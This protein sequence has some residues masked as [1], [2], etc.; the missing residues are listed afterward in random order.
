MINSIV[1]DSVRNMK[2]VYLCG[3]NSFQ[4]VLETK[5]MQLLFLVC[6]WCF[7][8]SF[9]SYIMQVCQDKITI[10]FQWSN[11]WGHVYTMRLPSCGVTFDYIAVS[12]DH[13]PKH[14]MTNVKSQ[15]IHAVHIQ[16]QSFS[17]ERKHERNINSTSVIWFI[18][19]QTA[20]TLPEIHVLLPSV[21]PHFCC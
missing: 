21:F 1:C 9:I 16:S 8:N 3:E 19:E 10:Y 20:T 15:K 13:L 17:M 2:N 7:A 14:P 5:T 4:I 11:D 18:Y 6:A 12:D